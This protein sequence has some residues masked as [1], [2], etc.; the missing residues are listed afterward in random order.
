[1]TKW[2]LSRKTPLMIALALTALSAWALNDVIVAGRSFTCENTCVVGIT[3][4]GG[5]YV[6]DSGGGWLRENRNDPNPR[7][8]EE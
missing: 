7:I 8:G 3:D 1:M 6:Y 2:K 4:L 5:W